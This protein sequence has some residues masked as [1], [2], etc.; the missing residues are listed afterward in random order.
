MRACLQNVLQAQPGKLNPFVEQPEARQHPKS[1]KRTD[2]ASRTLSRSGSS[3]SRTASASSQA[4]MEIT[5]HVI[6]DPLAIDTS[7]SVGLF[8]SSFVDMK[9]VVLAL[10]HIMDE[11]QVCALVCHGLSQMKE[12]RLSEDELFTL[13]TYEGL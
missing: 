13:R 10:Q 3:Y 7:P 11:Q 4:A 5:V 2:S 12:E 8:L 6:Q 9:S 1:I